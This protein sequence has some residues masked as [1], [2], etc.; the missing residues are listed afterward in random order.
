MQR[1]LVTLLI[2]AFW[3]AAAVLSGAAQEFRRETD[4]IPVFIDGESIL[5]PFA[6]GIQWPRVVLAD[7]DSDGDF[8]LLVGDH[9]GRVHFY[10]NIGT[11]NEHLFAPEPAVL[12]DIKVAARAAPTV[13]DIDND[14]DLDIFV[15]EA[16][17]TVSF[18]RNIG[19]RTDPDFVLV[20][21]K[22]QDIEAGPASFP[23][24]ADVDNDGDFDLF[25]GTGAL[26]F[27]RNVGGN[28]HWYRN[29]GTSEHPEFTLVTKHFA[30]IHVEVFNSRP[31]FS[32]IDGDGDLDLVVGSGGGS[33]QLYRNAGTATAHDYVL[34]P[35]T[36]AGIEPD[37]G[38]QVELADIDG[39]GDLDLFVT[40]SYGN[41]QFY[42]NVGTVTEFRFELVTEDF[43]YFL[44]DVGCLSTPTFADI[45]NDG[46]FD[47]FVG[48]E[49]GSIHFYRNTGT[50]TDP[51]FSLETRDFGDLW[52]E[53][54]SYEYGVG[55]SVPTFLDID[56]D[57]DLDLFVGAGSGELFFYR[58]TGTS[59]D[60]HFVRSTD[61]QRIIYPSHI[62][63]TFAD[64]DNDGD[65]DLFV[66][67]IDGRAAFYLNSGTA[68]SPLFVLVP[69]AFPSV[70]VVRLNHPRF[71]DI[72]DD[73][74]SDL[75]VGKGSNVTLHLS[76]GD[77][78]LYRNIG[79]AEEPNF[80]LETTS[81]ADVHVP[82]HASPAFVDIDGDGDLD[83]FLGEVDGGLYFYRNID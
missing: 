51:A 47:M 80:T 32:D 17:G 40:E 30:D 9:D 70:S 61:L 64:I 42:R 46:D 75:F 68:A 54:E 55:W 14:G 4:T 77:L 39:D 27:P 36:F 8:D 22:F 59:S 56:N 11:S 26:L 25:V 79:T 2:V 72:D 33:I 57:G 73:G 52:V 38:G 5:D 65:F 81:F 45:D 83:L 78:T 43:A 58:N 76:G 44:N 1:I 16:L 82:S 62:A 41:I 31:V 28:M 20:S 53:F 35:G 49:F 34:E 19:T 7:I 12:A 74:D 29:V 71:V 48:R 6:G 15:G 24:F 69:G 23:A 37:R 63:A 67:Y 50:A 60:P 21:A 10:R 66:R 13:V 3:A 18:Y